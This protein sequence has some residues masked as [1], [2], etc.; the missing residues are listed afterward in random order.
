M[1]FFRCFSRD[2]V[3]GVLAALEAE[4]NNWGNKYL[5]VRLAVSIN[6]I[7]LCLHVML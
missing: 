2:S 5:E 7:I 3:E 1:P 4:G 6:A